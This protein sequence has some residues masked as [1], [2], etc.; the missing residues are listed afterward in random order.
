MIPPIHHTVW[1]QL[2]SGEKPITSANVGVNM[3][4][5]NSTLK[6]RRDP[7]RA[8]VQALVSHAHAF[9]TKYAPT[10]Q[11]EIQQLLAK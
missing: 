6:Y 7:S 2:V 8:N 1:V 11:A 3:L 4:I 5:F 9:F 10:L